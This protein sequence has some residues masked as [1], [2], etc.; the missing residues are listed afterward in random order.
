M[1]DY[2]SRYYERW[3]ASPATRVA[4]AETT[5]RKARLAVAAAEYLLG[6]EVR[7]V[8][9]IGCGIGLWRAPLKRMRPEIRYVGVESSEYA[10][11]RFGESR[12]IRR[13][14]LGTIDSLKLGRRFDLVVCADVIQY[15]P[16]VDLRRGLAAIRRMLTGVAYIEAFTTEDSMEGDREGWIDRPELKMRKIFREAGLT[17]CGLYCWIDEKKIDNGN[18]L[19]LA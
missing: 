9:D 5:A 7:S 17:H 16:D 14:S 18:R 1:K 12:N 6:R 8:L 2:D 19:E 11:A 13:G 4:T 10:V 3:Y 15:V